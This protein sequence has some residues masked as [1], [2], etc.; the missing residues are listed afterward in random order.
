MIPR[1][2]PRKT[3]SHV[4]TFRDVTR[5]RLETKENSNMSVEARSFERIINSFWCQRYDHREH[6]ILL[7]RKRANKGM[8]RMNIVYLCLLLLFPTLPGKPLLTS[9]V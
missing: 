5:K 1:K 2:I 7:N 3:V 8:K 9:P 4:K 6:T